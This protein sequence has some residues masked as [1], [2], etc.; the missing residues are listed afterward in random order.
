MK[1]RYLVTYITADGEWKIHPIMGNTILDA[2]SN[3]LTRQYNLN[4]GNEETENVVKACQIYSIVT[5]V[6]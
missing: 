1:N 6:L 5:S 2:L 4:R 3:F